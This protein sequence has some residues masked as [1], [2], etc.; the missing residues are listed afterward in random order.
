[1]DTILRGCFL[2]RLTFHLHP[3]GDQSLISGESRE[4]DLVLRDGNPETLDSFEHPHF[5]M[6]I[7]H[8]LS[9]AASILSCSS[10]LEVRVVG[11][12]SKYKQP[13]PPLHREPHPPPLI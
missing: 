5:R 2:K 12:I 11:A 8:F 13:P 10:R 3:E 4:G 7:Q 1:M 9:F 6:K